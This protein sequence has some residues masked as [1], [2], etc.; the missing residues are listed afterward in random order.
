MTHFIV[1]IC[2]ILKG[3]VLFLPL[4]HSSPHISTNPWGSALERG[5]PDADSER[6]A[7]VRGDNGSRGAR[8]SRGGKRQAGWRLR[9]AGRPPAA[10]AGDFSRPGRGQHRGPDVRREGHRP[11]GGTRPAVETEGRDTTGLEAQMLEEAPRWEAP[12]PGGAA[13][14]QP[15]DASAR[16]EPV[17]YPGGHPQPGQAAEGGS[18]VGGAGGEEVLPTSAGH[19]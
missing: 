12:Q 15:L 11:R 6:G 7:S 10:D 4:F 5:Q 1:N 13:H 3:G 9:R 2:N 18:A 17:I 16:R 19:L 14:G 8:T